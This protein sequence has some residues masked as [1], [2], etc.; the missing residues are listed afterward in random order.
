MTVFCHCEERRDEAIPGIPA[1]ST[2][3]PASLMIFAE[4]WIASRMIFADVA[5][6][7]AAAA[8]EALPGQNIIVDGGYAIH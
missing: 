7:L 6:F 5:L 8:P 1:Q 4:T 3:M 2:L